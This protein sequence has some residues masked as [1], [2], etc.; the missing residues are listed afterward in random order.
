MRARG[1]R[2]GARRRGEGV[3]D[4]LQKEN[5]ASWRASSCDRRPCAGEGTARGRA[6]RRHIRGGPLVVP[7]CTVAALQRYELGSGRRGSRRGGSVPRLFGRSWRGGSRARRVPRSR[8]RPSALIQLALVVVRLPNA[9]RL[10]REPGGLGRPEATA[11]RMLLLGTARARE[12]SASS[13]RCSAACTRARPAARRGCGGE[14]HAPALCP[15]LHTAVSPMPYWNMRRASVRN[16]VVRPDVVF[17][18]PTPG[19]HI[20]KSGVLF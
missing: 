9:D 7:V 3:C 1:S 14:A 16:T 13:Y 5:A 18:L 15:H 10:A 4:G 2:R 11:S 20:S 17:R 12:L 19:L 6:P 8:G